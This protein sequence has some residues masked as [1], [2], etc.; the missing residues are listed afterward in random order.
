MRTIERLLT[1]M[2]KDFRHYYHEGISIESSPPALLLA[3]ADADQGGTRLQYHYRIHYSQDIKSKAIMTLISGYE[4]EQKYTT[5]EIEFNEVPQSVV[6][7]A[8]VWLKK[9]VEVLEKSGSEM[10]LNVFLRFID[11]I[12][13]SMGNSV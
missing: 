8:L 7:D 9:Q 12:E 4:H 1:V 2:C 5:R 13:N 6:S 11:I 10:H 3:Y